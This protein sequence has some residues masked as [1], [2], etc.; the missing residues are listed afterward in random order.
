MLNT[1]FRPHESYELVWD[2]IDLDA[3]TITA[4][5]RKAKA[6]KPRIVAIT[7]DT[8][9]ALAAHRKNQAQER[10]LMGSLWPDA[11]RDLVYVNEN[12]RPLDGPTTRRLLKRWTVTGRIDKHITPYDLRHTVAS[13]A[14]DAGVNIVTLAD[15]L[16]ND[17]Q[18]LLRYYRKPITPIMTL[19]VDL[20]AEAETR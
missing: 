17:Q 12:G 11:H 20:T 5:P 6:D 2:D 15:Y 16:G 1:G 8:R 19:G 14:A 18:T 10:L 7:G 13:L 9:T 4:R 3:M